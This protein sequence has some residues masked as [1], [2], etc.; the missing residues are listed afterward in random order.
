MHALRNTF[1]IQPGILNLKPQSSQSEVIDLTQPSLSGGKDNA[2][3]GSMN[4]RGSSPGICQLNPGESRRGNVIDLTQSSA[5][6]VEDD[7]QSEQEQLFRVQTTIVGKRYYKGHMNDR[8]MIHLVREPR[9]P[10]G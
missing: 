9:N 6:V 2:L 10:Y 3:Q 4:Q 1:S 7:S 5:A 8:E